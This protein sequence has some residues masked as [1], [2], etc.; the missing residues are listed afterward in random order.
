MYSL[1]LY[2]KIRESASN[3]TNGH[4]DLLFAKSAKSNAKPVIDRKTVVFL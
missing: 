2:D 1:L 3:M 4:P